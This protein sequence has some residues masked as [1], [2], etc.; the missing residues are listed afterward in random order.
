M[1][2]VASPLQTEGA[3]ELEDGLRRTTSIHSLIIAGPVD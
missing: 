2:R 1:A 3:D